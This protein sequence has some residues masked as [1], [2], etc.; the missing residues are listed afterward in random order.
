[1]CDVLATRPRCVSLVFD[2]PRN[3]RARLARWPRCLWRHQVNQLTQRLIFLFIGVIVGCRSAPAR[4]FDADVG[5]WLTRDPLGYRDGVNLTAYSRSDPVAHSDPFGLLSNACVSCGDPQGPRNP[6]PPGQTP[7]GGA[8]PGG[9]QP[10]GIYVPEEPM[11]TCQGRDIW[12]P[13]ARALWEQIRQRCPDMARY[14][15]VTCSQCPPLP[16]GPGGN[17]QVRCGEF[18]PGAGGPT[19]RICV[20][21]G[22][23]PNCDAKETLRHELVHA[24]QA[25][26]QYGWRRNMAPDDP[27]WKKWKDKKNSICAEVQAYQTDGSCGPPLPGGYTSAE[28]CYCSKACGSLDDPGQPWEGDR[29]GCYSQCVDLLFQHRCNQGIA[30]PAQGQ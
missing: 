27:F 12:T 19:V 16:P 28:D 5:R 10:G 18:V 13:E 6:F 23:Q 1:M 7:P 15:A 2:G 29:N 8:T 9:V 3:L 25:C 26:T 21:A 22:G 20:D 30:V 11:S 17:P 14:F 4:V 24:L